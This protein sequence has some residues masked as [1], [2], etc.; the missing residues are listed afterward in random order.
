MR[1]APNDP[2]RPVRD[3]WSQSGTLTTGVPGQVTM[4][5]DFPVSE[6]HT[7]M[8][9]IINPGLGIPINPIAVVRWSVEGNF[10]SRRFNVG[11]GVALSAPSQAVR[12]IIDD[13]TPFLFINV[14]GTVAVTE[15][16]MA[17]VFSSAQFFGK[18]IPLA[19]SSQS[20][21]IYVLSSDIDGVGNATLLT[22]YT[23]PTDPAASAIIEAAYTVG[24]QIAP[25]VRANDEIP[26]TLNAVIPEQ[27][28]FIP[29]PALNFVTLQPKGSV[30]ANV[31]I[32][33][34]MDAGVRSVEI[35]ADATFPPGPQLSV[36]QSVAGFV[37]KIYSI[38]T[39]T[40]GFIAI[41]ANATQIEILNEDPTPGITVAV[42][43]TW[44]IDG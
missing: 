12:I 28:G 6:V 36:I 19:F 24:V 7:I 20:N 32:P 11:N 30:G 21:I 40:S 23:G 35:T 41:A 25:G 42:T 3:G 39:P 2:T 16:S 31:T 15:G 13:E 10:V 44:G 8:F 17:V 4:Q 5:V 38:I 34:P 22:P 9:G 33:I 26:V 1:Q 14:I 43:I 29:A 18:G 27:P 37:V